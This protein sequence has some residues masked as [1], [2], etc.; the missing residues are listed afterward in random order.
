MVAQED[1]VVEVA[2]GEV[3]VVGTEGEAEDLEEVPNSSSLQK[4]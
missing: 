3:A 1:L 2:T 4:N